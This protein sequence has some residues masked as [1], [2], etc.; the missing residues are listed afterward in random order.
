MAV[1]VKDRYGGKPYLNWDT[2]SEGEFPQAD[3]P[4]TPGN[5]PAQRP[6]RLRR[7]QLLSPCLEAHA[8]GPLLMLPHP[9]PGPCLGACPLWRLSASCPG[10]SPLYQAP[11]AP[12]RT[13]AGARYVAGC[14]D[15]CALLLAVNEWRLITSALHPSTRQSAWA[16]ADDRS[17]FS[18]G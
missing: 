8:L 12:A 16:E 17:G 14:G 2:K 4:T 15:E 6:R 3:P 10:R 13:S 18:V 9:L 7:S 11:T 1:G 5:V